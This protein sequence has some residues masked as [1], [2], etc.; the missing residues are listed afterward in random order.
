MQDYNKIWSS[1]NSDYE[2]SC[3]MGHDIVVEKY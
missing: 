1:Q 2:D 3:L